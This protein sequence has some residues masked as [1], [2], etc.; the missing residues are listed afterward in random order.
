[1]SAYICDPSH[2]GILAAFAVSERC[3]IR[4]FEVMGEPVLVAQAVARSL[5]KENIRSVAHRYPDD[6]DGN[7]PGP[8]L[9]D[10]EIEEAAAIYAAYF[11][12]N[13]QHLP[14]VQILKLVHCLDYQSCETDDWRQTS[15]FKQLEWITTYAINRL[16]GYE[17]AM[18]SF[19]RL[20]P[21]VEA[22]YERNVTT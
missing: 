16:P 14:P 7:R 6:T 2:I 11:L 20:I 8:C 15:A 12:A 10:A 19:E 22:L 5:A 17:D 3:A 4:E 9:K 21:E 13:P 18:W 1:M